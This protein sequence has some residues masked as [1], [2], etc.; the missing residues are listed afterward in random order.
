MPD[1]VSWLVIE[2]GWTVVGPDGEDV[3]RVVEI[4]GDT[5]KDIF[6]GLAVSHGLLGRTKYVPAERV[7]EIVEGE[8]RLDVDADH[9]GS[10]DDHEPQPPSAEF[11]A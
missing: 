9:V 11:R 3:G 7:A 4:V 8:V 1:P 5:G 6:N 10:L 2:P